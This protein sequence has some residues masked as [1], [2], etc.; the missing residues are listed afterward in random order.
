MDAQCVHVQRRPPARSAVPHPATDERQRHGLR[1]PDCTLLEVQGTSCPPNLTQYSFETCLPKSRLTGQ[2]RWCLWRRVQECRTARAGRHSCTPKPTDTRCL[3]L[4][5]RGGGLYGG[6]TE[7]RREDGLCWWY[8]S[9]W[10]SGRRNEGMQPY[11]PP[12][13]NRMAPYAAG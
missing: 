2:V 7:R 10:P 13:P 6:M 1:M 11:S 8:V 5:M 4:L 12:T 9:A 3:L